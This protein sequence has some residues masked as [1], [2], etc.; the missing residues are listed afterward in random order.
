MDRPPR[1]SHTAAPVKNDRVSGPL[2]RFVLARNVPC[3]LP[4]PH[5][6][7]SAFK[8]LPEFFIED[9]ADYYL[10]LM[11]YVRL[12]FQTIVVTIALLGTVLLC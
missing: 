7:P 9:V 1:G 5:E 2:F 3:R 6:V 8:L 4:L 12:A 10:Y 11:R